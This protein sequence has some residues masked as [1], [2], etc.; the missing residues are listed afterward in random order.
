LGKRV[1]SKVKKLG[2]L[3]WRTIGVLK[4]KPTLHFYKEQEIIKKI[5]YI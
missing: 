4:L 5:A 1:V 3:V 2:V